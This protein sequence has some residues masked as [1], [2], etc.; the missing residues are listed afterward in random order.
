[1]EQVVHRLVA[2]NLKKQVYVFC[3]F[4][5]VFQTHDIGMSQAHL[6]R[7]FLL[8]FLFAVLSLQRL[9]GN[10][11]A[12]KN[13]FVLANPSELEAGCE[14]TFSKLFTFDVSYNAAI[15]SFFFNNDASSLLNLDFDIFLD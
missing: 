14:R 11:L 10:N 1:M 7:D 8:K 13:F 3:V 2:A 9:F 6:Q 4:K 12:C 5:K 15:W